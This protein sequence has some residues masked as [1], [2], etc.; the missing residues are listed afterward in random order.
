VFAGLTGFVSDCLGLGVRESLITIPSILHYGLSIR[1]LRIAADAGLSIRQLNS[2]NH[3]LSE[4]STTG[5]Y[6]TAESIVS[7]ATDANVGPNTA[8]H[9]ILH[10]TERMLPPASTGRYS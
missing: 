4:V 9:E 5:L 1:I 7:I 3:A 6:N 8:V 2:N 10:H